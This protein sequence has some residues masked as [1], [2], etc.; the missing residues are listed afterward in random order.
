MRNLNCVPIL[1]G[2]GLFCRR[3]LFLEITAKPCCAHPG[4]RARLASCSWSSWRD[5]GFWSEGP[6][7]FVRKT[8]RTL[9]DRARPARAVGAGRLFQSPSFGH[10]RTS[11]QNPSPVELPRP[12]PPH[13]WRPAG[14]RHLPLGPPPLL[15]A[16]TPLLGCSLQRDPQQCSLRTT[17]HLARLTARDTSPD[18]SWA[19]PWSS[20]QH[21]QPLPVLFS[22]CLRGGYEPRAAEATARPG[23][24]CN[25]LAP[26]EKRQNGPSLSPGLG[27]PRLDG[28][29]RSAH[30]SW[31]VP[32][33]PHRD[34]RWPC[35]VSW[36]RALRRYLGQRGG[37]FSEPGSLR[38]LTPNGS[39]TVGPSWCTGAVTARAD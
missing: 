13:P 9:L 33:G 1:K 30:A 27:C 25:R 11:E 6:R 23:L 24:I 29:A 14:L 37:S 2:S 28:Q 16:C 34:R 19:R 36:V 5:G 21:L 15:P 31:G 12:R 20:H 8:K 3:Y 10:T 18:T 26:S 7:A 32:P 4:R 35:R 39:A 38:S 22:P 17:C